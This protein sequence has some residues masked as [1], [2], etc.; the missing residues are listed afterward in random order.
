MNTHTRTGKTDLL[1]VANQ[2]LQPAQQKQAKKAAN[3]W[4]PTHA[5]FK[6]KVYYLD[7]GAKSYYSYDMYHQY[8]NGVKKHV[9]DEEIG[10]TKLF[11]YLSKI[12]ANIQTA[13]IYAT[14]EKEKGTDAA[15]YNFAVY[16]CVHKGA[17]VEPVINQKVYFKGG[18]LSTEILKMM[19]GG[20]Q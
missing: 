19:E 4:K 13:I 12:T 5:R 9:T 11:S 15:R 20:K 1:T 3:K 18:F 14:D 2:L 17:G 8:T 7:G 6:L 10:Y 16:K